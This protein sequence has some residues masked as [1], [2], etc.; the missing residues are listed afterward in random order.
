VIL[1]LSNIAD[2]Q[3]RMLRA[4][5]CI[6]LRVYGQITSMSDGPEGGSMQIE[7]VRSDFERDSDG[8]N[9]QFRDAAASALA[10]FGTHG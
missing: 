9:Q 2:P 3:L 4:G 6:T 7:V 10:T 8:T 1:H 5:C